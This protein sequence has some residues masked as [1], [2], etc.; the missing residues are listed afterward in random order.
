ME[1]VELADWGKHP[2][3]LEYFVTLCKQKL[4][5]NLQFHYDVHLL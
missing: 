4:Y 3:C 5:S 2:F 1:K